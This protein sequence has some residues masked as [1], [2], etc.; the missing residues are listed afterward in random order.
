MA[1]DDQARFT[2][3]FEEHRQGVHAF[4]LARPWDAEVARDLLQE[5]QPTLAATWWSNLNDQVTAA[6]V[7][8]ASQADAHWAGPTEGVLAA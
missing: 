5:P 7:L 6:V 4:L 1:S 2:R 8:A 3:L